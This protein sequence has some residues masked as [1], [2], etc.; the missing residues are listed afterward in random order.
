MKPPEYAIKDGWKKIKHH[1]IKFIGINSE[2]KRHF[3]DIFA[4]LMQAESHSFL[5]LYI[6]TLVNKHMYQF[7]NE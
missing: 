3:I 6:F 2:G 5:T 7:L 1:A 4:C